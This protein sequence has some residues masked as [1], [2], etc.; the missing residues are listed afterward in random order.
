MRLIE[1]LV[2]GRIAKIFTAAHD[3]SQGG[4]SATLTEMV[5][6]HNVGATINIENVGTTLISES[7]GRVV[8][9]IDSAKADVLKE[10]AVKNQIAITKIGTTGGSSLKINGA[11]ISLTELRQ[12]HTETFEKLF[13]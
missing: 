7:P 12:A 2:A 10:L 1:L 8:V 6:R 13:G 3:L 4:L 9:A 5:L 11:D